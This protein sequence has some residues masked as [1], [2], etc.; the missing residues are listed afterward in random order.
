MN[1]FEKVS[2]EQY[3]SAHDTEEVELLKETWNDIIIPK[4]ATS[5]SGAYDFYSPWSFVLYPGETIRIATGIRVFLD[6]D[7]CLIGI[8]RSGLG[9]KYRLQLDNTVALID[10]D[11]IESDNEGHIFI[12]ITNDSNDFT[13]VLKINKG[14]AF[15][16]GIIVQ[17][18]KTDDDAVITKRNGGIGSTS[19]K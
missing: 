17:Y 18:F 3:K 5:K 8:P 14:D 9:F 4:R 15:M 10:A 16:Q 12:K 6:D 11:Y 19:N 1:K 13:K 7:K 2:F